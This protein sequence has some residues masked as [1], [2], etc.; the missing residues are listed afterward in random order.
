MN[1]SFLISAALRRPSR[2]IPVSPHIVLKFPVVVGQISPP[3]HLLLIGELL[4]VFM[5]TWWSPHMRGNMHEALHAHFLTLANGVASG[6]GC[7]S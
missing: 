2:C 4:D 7:L 1:G 3:M 6:V 5:V